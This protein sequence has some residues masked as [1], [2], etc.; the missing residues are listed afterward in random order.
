MTQYIMINHGVGTSNDWESYFQMLRDGN[1]MVGG[2][3]LGR[4]ISLKDSTYSEALTPTTTG[5]IVIHADTL[6]QAKELMSRSPVHKSGGTV[7]LFPLI[8]S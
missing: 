2:S 6:D 5:Y 8:E 4:G 3:A 1:H 7:E